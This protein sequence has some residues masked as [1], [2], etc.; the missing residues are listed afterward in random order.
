MKLSMHEYA[1]LDCIFHQ[2][3]YLKENHSIDYMIHQ[4]SL[5]KQAIYNIINRLINKGY[6]I[7]E[8]TNLYLTD[9]AIIYFIN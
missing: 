1:V 8:N 6:L 5:T 2:V 3:H 4:F 9:K 7:R